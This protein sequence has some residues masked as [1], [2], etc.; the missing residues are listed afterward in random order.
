LKP[1]VDPPGLALS[2]GLVG[3]RIRGRLGPAAAAAASL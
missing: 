3:M 2:N 1:Q